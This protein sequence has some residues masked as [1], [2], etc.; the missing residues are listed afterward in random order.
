MEPGPTLAW[1]CPASGLL[2][3]SC[4]ALAL[5]LTRTTGA[6]SLDL[7]SD[8]AIMGQEHLLENDSY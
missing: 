7:V 1:V 5:L 4:L 8:E 3:P 6:L 2:Q